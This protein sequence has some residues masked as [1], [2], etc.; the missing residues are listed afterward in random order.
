M[1]RLGYGRL[2]VG[3]VALAVVIG[4]SW[5][6]LEYLVPS[7]PSSVTIA[8]G[9]KGTTFDYFGERYRAR[10]ARAGVELNVRETAGALENFRL[11][12]DPKS[13]VQIAFATGGI[14]N[15]TQAPEL[16][17]MGLISNVP[18]WI[19]YSSRQSLDLTQLKGK[20]IAV[21]PEGSGARYDAERILSRANID[22]KTTTLLPVAGDSAVEA[23]KDGRADAALLVGGSNAPSV[24]SLLN[25]PNVR[26]MN[27][28]SADAFMRVFPDLVRLVLPKG[29]IQLDPPNP[30]DDVTLVGT[31]AKVLIRD[32]LHPAIIQLLAETLKEEHSGAGLFQ[33]SG[34]F[35]AIDDPEFA[36]PSVAVEYYRNGPS[37]LA[38]Y[39]PLWTTT[40]VQRS[41]AFLVAALAIVFPAF[42]FAPRLY[43]WFVRQ[44]FRQLYQRLRAIE[45]ALQEK[46]TVANTEAL[47]AEL[48][49]IERST[50]TVPMRHSDLY[51]ILRY[52]LDRTRSRLSEASRDATLTQVSE[53]KGQ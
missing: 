26:L 7:P 8:T 15:R 38:K 18:F 6:I 44:R 30:P 22:A 27:F 16:R 28:S 17:S 35:P 48:D 13:N 5:I 37:L 47:Q 42:G 3:L 4:I 32:D 20:R 31:T 49:D 51:F 36:V 40:Y 14:S 41:I 21:G 24:E 1:Q 46:L 39:L 12:R 45:N 34:E 9:R 29:V 43:E 52:H 10:F 50:M 11:L 2:I 19:F 25:N 23:L 53:A 33:R